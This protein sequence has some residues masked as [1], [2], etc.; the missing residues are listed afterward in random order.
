MSYSLR[1]TPRS[2]SLV[3][4]A[5]VSWSCAS[6]EE[7]GAETDLVLGALGEGITTVPCRFALQSE[8]VEGDTVV[9]GDLTV[10]AVRASGA[11]EINVHFA[12]FQP[13]IPGNPVPL[14]SVLGGPG[15]S[16]GRSANSFSTLFS[17]EE[18][19]A[20]GRDFLIVEQRG[21]GESRP[22]TQCDTLDALA[23]L[24]ADSP[25]EEAAAQLDRCQAALIAQ[26]V[27]LEGFNVLEIADDLESLRAAL[28]YEQIALSGTSYGSRIGLEY[29]RRHEAHLAAL[30][31]DSV[32]PPNRPSFAH[33][34]EDVWGTFEAIFAACEEDASCAAAF[35]DFRTTFLDFY[36][37]IS[38]S[39]IQLGTGE[40]LLGPEEVTLL[41]VFGATGDPASIPA[42]VELVRGAEGRALLASST[43]GALVQSALTDTL[44]DEVLAQGMYHSITCADNTGLGPDEID[45]QVADLPTEAA[46]DG[47]RFSLDI[48]NAVCERWPSAELPESYFEPVS[49]SRV[50]V[51]L[52]NG[53]FDTLTAHAAAVQA[54]ET[55][56]RAT[57]VT[58]PGAGHSPIGF[59]ADGGA[60]VPCAASLARAFLADPEAELDT[61]C[62]ETVQPSFPTSVSLGLLSF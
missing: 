62:A 46:Q 52:I 60:T 17:P 34:A 15:Q 10:P 44:A 38:D 39:P 18:I 48:F 28:D 26:G 50:P 27:P 47:A 14:F 41:L 58:L 55:L 42:L 30:I 45:A 49:S 19:D 2:L 1:F 7:S 13:R 12:R 4:L 32:T 9:C 20:L 25:A 5:C 8:Q 22:A 57:L 56:E 24:T 53:T 40:L 31:I 54:A 23:I 37:E 16:W 36:D 6:A 43:V 29:L 33:A 35:P 3:A 51:L 59:L 21:T 11:G 61:S